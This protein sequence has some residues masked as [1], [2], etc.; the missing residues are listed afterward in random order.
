[1][2]TFQLEQ[3]G[4]EIQQILNITQHF[5]TEYI[6]SESAQLTL[7]H[8]RNSFLNNYGQTDN[9]IATLVEAQEGLCFTLTFGTEIANY[10]R[11]VPATGDTIYLNGVTNGPN[12]YVYVSSTS[13]M[14]SIYF[15]TVKINTNT[16][17]WNALSSFGP[18]SQD[19]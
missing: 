14:D 3:T 5:N 10:F 16:W 15:Y 2:N 6:I 1:M 17:V 8:C 13:L 19:I 9:I 18:W 7:N 4:L 12:K 11:I